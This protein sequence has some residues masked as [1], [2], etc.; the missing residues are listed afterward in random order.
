MEYWNDGKWKNGMVEYWNIGILDEKLPP[1]ILAS[2][3]FH[4][5][6]I[7]SFHHSITHIP[8]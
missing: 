7:P 1:L 2:V 3:L 8:W 6:I 5:S 4:Y